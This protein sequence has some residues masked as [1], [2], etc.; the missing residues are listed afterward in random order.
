M[1][2]DVCKQSAA[3]ADS[4]TTSIR[5]MRVPSEHLVEVGGI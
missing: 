5:H 3:S 2:R 1:K 4:S